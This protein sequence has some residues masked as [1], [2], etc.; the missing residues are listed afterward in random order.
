MWCFGASTTVEMNQREND[1]ILSHVAVTTIGVIWV[2]VNAHCWN[3]KLVFNPTPVHSG[4]V[5]SCCYPALLELAW[6]IWVT[7]SRY[8]YGAKFRWTQ[9]CLP[10]KQELTPSCDLEVYT[11]QFICMNDTY[12]RAGLWTHM[13]Y[14]NCCCNHLWVLRLELNNMYGNEWKDSDL[15]A[16]NQDSFWCDSII[17]FDEEIGEDYDEFEGIRTSTCLSLRV[18]LRWFYF[19]CFPMGYMSLTISQ[20]YPVGFGYILYCC[21]MRK[22]LLIR[23]WCAIQVGTEIPT[24]AWGEC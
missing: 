6:Y 21:R 20:C 9:H 11:K 22:T 12:K 16:S 24:L 8:E 23:F 3:T 14:M 10:W 13:V 2:Y 4:T 17:C 1:V 7:N 15:L 5:M 18:S 19:F